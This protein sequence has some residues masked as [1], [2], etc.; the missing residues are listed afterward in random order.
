MTHLDD[1]A[2]KR[3]S[4][5]SLSRL[6]DAGC[7]TGWHLPTAEMGSSI[8]VDIATEMLSIGRVRGEPRLLNADIR[9]L[10]FQNG[11]FDL[12][13]CRLVLAH[14]VD[15]GQAYLELGRTAAPGAPLIVTDMHSDAI[16]AGFKT[17]FKD[18]SGRTRFIQIHKR[19]LDD[20]VR[21][22][23]DAGFE[24]KDTVESAIGP[25]IRSFFEDAGERRLYGRHQ[26]HKVLLAMRFVKRGR[27][28]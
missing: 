26:G 16:Q 14:L 2:V 6:L 1:L 3:L 23:D 15:A 4:P 27:Y 9:A 5:G 7:G 8:G 28:E 13:W 18:R 17:S 24:L 20:H 22:A 25:E 11:E 12:L 21:L 10:P 19:T